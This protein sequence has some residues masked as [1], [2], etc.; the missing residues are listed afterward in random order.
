[1]PPKAATRRGRPDEATDAKGP[2]PANSA[3]H[4]K[5][6]ATTAT[7]PLHAAAAASSASGPAG[8]SIVTAFMMVRP[9]G[10][11]PWGF[12][13]EPIPGAY[14]LK[15]VDV[16]PGGLA[17][18]AGLRANDIIVSLDGTVFSSAPQLRSHILRGSTTTVRMN[19]SRLKSEA[20]IAPPIPRLPLPPRAPPQAP[21]LAA[22]VAA[23]PPRPP[24][25]PV[26]DPQL[27]APPVVSPDPRKSAGDKVQLDLRAMQRDHAELQEEKELQSQQAADE[28]AVQK[29]MDF[30]RT[31]LKAKPVGAK[32]AVSFETQQLGHLF[33]LLMPNAAAE[34][35]ARRTAEEMDELKGILLQQ[36][37]K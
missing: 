37:Q 16:T 35:P 13:I 15:I 25:Q 24:P 1:M 18:N 20:A 32:P 10:D 21:A 29:L 19:V 11:V 33:Q 9:S 27:A 12:V 36:L 4:G 14:K 6:K 31:P 23:I 2:V 3:D 8:P 34:A 26:A 7:P 28:S 22:A 30:R 5:K 17:D